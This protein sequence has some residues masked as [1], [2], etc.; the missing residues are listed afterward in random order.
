MAQTTVDIQVRTKGQE[1]LERFA[2]SAQ[3]AD[4]SLNKLNPKLNQT[5]AA[6]GRVGT[7]AAGAA[8]GVRA[9]GTAFAAALGPISAAVTAMA[10]FNAAIR[11]IADVD[12]A[13][14]KVRTLGVDSE[15]LAERLK[16][17][18]DE[19]DGTRSVAELVAGA[20]DVA[21]AGFNTAAES[22]AVLKAASQGATGGFS[23]LNTVANATTSVLNAYGKSARDANFIVDQF[24]QT[25]NDGKIV[26]AQ[27][28]QNIGKVA[29]AAAG[30]KI[31]LS[32]VNAVIAQ[33]TAS[34]VQSEVA[35]TGLKSALARLASGEAA[36][37]LKDAGIEISAATIEADGL[38]GTLKKLE[39]LDTG[40]VFK[41]LG[42]EAAPALLPVLQNLEKFEELLKNQENAAGAAK[43]AQVEATNTINGAWNKVRV[44][45]QNLFSD[46][47]AL[48]EGII[49][50]LNTVARE[51][52]GI[53]KAAEGYRL[54]INDLATTFENLKASLPSQG[55]LRVVADWIGEIG[56]QAY[57]ALNPLGNLIDKFN[58]LARARAAA[59]ARAED[60]YNVGGIK[61]D[62]N[63]VPINPPPTVSD[64]RDKLRK[65]K[66]RLE[67]LF[68]TRPTPTLT[69]GGSTG[70]GASASAAA[71]EAE[72]R[73]KAIE[74]GLRSSQE[75]LA[76]MR[77]D[78]KVSEAT[79][80]LM[81]DQEKLELRRLQINQQYDS[82]M[83]NAL[84]N[85]LSEQQKIN[86]EIERG[87]ALRKASIDAQ[88][89][90]MDSA[91]GEFTDFFK[92]QPEYA[93]M[94]ND[95]LS[96]TD[97]L[98]KGAY[99]TVANGLTSG[100]QGLIEGTKSWSGCAQ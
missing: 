1:K 7:S 72:R 24:I 26:V 48:A 61:Y 92:Q 76:V 100:I 88:K 56:R 28:A 60:I 57:N 49:P 63:M 20:Y 15:E 62:K 71:D 93:K 23:D 37:A 75:S 12:F 36:K 5:A 66:E 32:E 82:Q 95:E 74:D 19:L 13:L 97:Q 99:D 43:A 47:A 91:Q 29:S 77:Q 39:G 80:E 41:A 68:K 54:I 40:Q 96:T 18:S 17:V 94:F 90:M 16:L 34:G 69:S 45:V 79:S 67:E 9:F 21:S 73:A 83:R 65:D 25:Q 22:A 42:S 55:A 86:I 33:A 30:L 87:L 2:K 44:A 84:E 3:K 46:Q 31:P 89:G 53:A 52:D 10:G 58:E 35:F 59:A 51:I 78:L 11:T 85:E 4:N 8:G 6:A 70:G 64:E 27:Y 50:L 81:A 14:A 98:L 38:L